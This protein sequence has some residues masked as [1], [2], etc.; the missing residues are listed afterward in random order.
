MDKTLDA[1]QMAHRLLMAVTLAMVVL[2]FSIQR[3]SE[4]YATAKE[5][6][7]Y[8]GRA[9]ESLATHR[10]AVYDAAYDRSELRTSVLAWLSTHKSKQTTVAIS[11][12]DPDGIAV[13]DPN[14]DPHITVEEEVRFVDNVFSNL[15][16]PFV[17][18]TANR[19][20]VFRA[21]EKAFPG[22][23][24]SI[25]SVI[26][27]VRP[28]DGNAAAITGPWACSL[29]VTS[30]RPAGPVQTTD[31]TDL[32]ITTQALELRDR[33]L[34]PNSIDVDSAGWLKAHGFGDWED[35]RVAPIFAIRE[36][37][38]DIRT[39]DVSDVEAFLGQQQ[40][41]ESKSSEQKMEVFGQPLNGAVSTMLSA[42]LTLAT[43]T[44]FAALAIHARRIA[45]GNERAVRESPFL[46]ILSHWVGKIV[47]LCT[48]LLLPVAATA[49]DLIVVFPQFRDQWSGPSWMAASISRW[50]CSAG[51][52][53]LGATV[54]AIL[55]R[56]ASGARLGVTAPQPPA[57]D[58]S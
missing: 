39:Q 44:Y 24:P 1:L 29:V 20:D 8:L 42:L 40:I 23:V 48:V 27:R 7:Q 58:F 13:P 3:P 53:L 37:W 52:A 35:N 45:A 5:E 6:L 4:N 57:Q 16:L 34:G 31:S 46:G 26:V 2:G 22:Q 19:Q 47:I 55:T 36:L 9:L 21:L 14:R 32:D 51:S 18:C 25:E 50:T 12:I 17:V 33:Y 30:V 15:Y 38:P 54:L 11:T 10:E 28:R 43:L 56:T 41:L 49:F